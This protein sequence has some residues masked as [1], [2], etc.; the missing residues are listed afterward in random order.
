MER[1]IA[2]L[3]NPIA[4][5]GN[6][7]GVR[8]LIEKRLSAA[9]TEFLTFPTNAE[10]KY[11]EVR[12]KIL[13][14]GFTDV[15]VA[16]GDGTISSVVNDLRDTGVNFGL[17][18]CGSGNGLALCAGIPKKAEKAIELLFTG[19]PAETDAFVINNNFSCMLSGLGF[20]AQVAHD[21]AKQTKRGL[22]TY[23]RQTYTNF[24]KARPYRFEIITHESAIKTEA[25]F[26]SIANSNQFGNRFTIAPKASLNDGLLDIVVVQKMNKLQ[27][28]VSVLYQVMNGEVKEHPYKKDGVMYYQAPHV[29]IHNPQNAPLHIDG[30]PKET[31]PSFTIQ[32]IPRAF[33]L[34]QPVLHPA[35]IA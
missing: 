31:S 24:L 32:I 18:P 22:I 34:I 29:V 28:I 12:D 25:Y 16:G 10:G 6:R 9:Q 20:D 4:G 11:D 19:Q 27:M 17:I 3:L 35:A 7:S 2:F 8:K 13:H 1:K 23:I 15:V 30:D 33:R 5:S 26:I 21:F 14:E